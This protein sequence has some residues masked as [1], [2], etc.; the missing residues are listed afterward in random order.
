MVIWTSNRETG[1]KGRPVKPG[2][3]GEDRPGHVKRAVDQ[4]RSK[5]PRRTGR[6]RLGCPGP[7]PSTKGE[8]RGAWFFRLVVPEADG[9]TA[10]TP[11]RTSH[12]IRSLRRASSR[13]QVQRQQP[14]ERPRQCE[15]QRNRE[16]GRR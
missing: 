13:Q 11:G 8:C 16:V 12:K 2:E 6:P 9:G 14:D 5:P 4:R 3:C 7:K 1:C 10:T 15:L